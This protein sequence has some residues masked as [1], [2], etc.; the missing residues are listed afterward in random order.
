M[1]LLAHYTL[2]IISIAILCGS[3]VDH[4]NDE[5]SDRLMNNAM[6]YAMRGFKP[7]YYNSEG[8]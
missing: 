7:F 8:E 1:K 2:L 6:E 4:A 3:I 5:L